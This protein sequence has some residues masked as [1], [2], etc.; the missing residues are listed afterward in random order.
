MKKLEYIAT[1]GEQG[2]IDPLLI[3]RRIL[4]V[5]K[6]GVGMSKIVTGT[7]AEKQAQY[8]NST[9]AINFASKL[10]PLEDVIVLYDDQG[11]VCFP[12]VIPTF[13][14]PDAKAGQSYSASFF[15][16]GTGQFTMSNLVKPAWLTIPDPTT[17]VSF[18]GTPAISDA[19]SNTV[20]FTLSNA[21][22]SVNFSQTFNVLVP[23]AQFEATTFVSGN[24]LNDVEIA[25]LSGTP[26][27]VI[28]VTLDTLTNT[29]GGNLKVNGA[30]ATVGDTYN[31]TLGVS[32]GLLNV[33]ID[34]ISNPHTVIL[35][36]F[37]ITAV[38]AGEIG[39]SKT[40]QISKVF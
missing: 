38:S 33:E 25:N 16:T 21:C 15:I 35:G 5:M 29:N 24:R 7:P 1:G 20:S 12:V 37:T 8:I 32:G 9:G 34:G 22:G 6:D 3:G 31:V 13:T 2:F 30:D 28:T 18:S 10:N 14:L 11:D 26:G 27:V 36:H 19:G 17:L 39:L 4:S 40:Y 23:P